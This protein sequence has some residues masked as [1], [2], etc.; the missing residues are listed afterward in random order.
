MSE[1]Y[2]WLAEPD[3]P[4]PREVTIDGRTGTIWLKRLTAGQR[5]NLL[6]GLKVG[7]SPGKENVVELDLAENEHQRQL[8]VFYSLCNADGSKAFKNLEHVKNLPDDRFRELARLV[9]KFTSDQ[10]ADL[11]K[12]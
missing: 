10:G 12:S 11:G 7:H 9:E 8:L 4:E 3:E 6:K 2:E 5:Q 1:F